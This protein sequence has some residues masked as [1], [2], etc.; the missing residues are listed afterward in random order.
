[1]RRTT[2][3]TALCFTGLVAAAV[4]GFTVLPQA[5]DP[6]A[7]QAKDT[8]KKA[9]VEKAPLVKK[10]EV[11]RNVFVEIE[12]K[13]AVRVMVEAYVCLRNGFLEHLL[14]RRRTKEHEAILAADIDARHLHT[15]LLLCGAEPGK[16][17]AL[18]P[19][20]TPPSGTTVKITLAYINKEEKVVKVPAQ[21][22]VRNIKTKKDLQTDWVFAGSGFI[23]D[24]DD[25]AKVFY[26]ANNGDVIC[27]TNFST[28]LLDLPILSPDGDVDYE[29]HSERI[30]PVDT[31]VLVIVEPVRPKKK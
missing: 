17:I 3:L 24:E 10:V 13:K 16:T 21:Q 26:L 19:Q 5:R 12:D 18:Q 11:G 29:A 9:P 27:V 14:C 1:M 15:A 2:W 25:P 20:G 30:P 8:E 4:A 7:K 22:W 28:A 31:P 6:G 23:V